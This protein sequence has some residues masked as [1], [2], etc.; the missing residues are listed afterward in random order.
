MPVCPF[1]SK[2]IKGDQYHLNRH[3][4]VKH[5]DQKKKL[6]CPFC[7]KTYLRPKDLKRHVQD[8]HEES[9]EDECIQYVEEEIQ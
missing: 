9:D 8:K 2:D 7:S 1:C 3:I 6:H 5:L 4:N